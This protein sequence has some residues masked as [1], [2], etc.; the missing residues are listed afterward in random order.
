MMSKFDDVIN[1]EAKVVNDHFI[2]QSMLSSNTYVTN[3]NNHPAPR[4]S[5][6]Q[7]NL[8]VPTVLFELGK[9]RIIL[10]AYASNNILN[11]LNEGETQPNTIAQENTRF[12][13]KYS[14]IK[15]EEEQN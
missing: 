8:I 15:V 14:D 5:K 9:I 11:L 6:Q 12:Q 4:M 1:I 13:K 3:P 7:W 2:R 10:Q